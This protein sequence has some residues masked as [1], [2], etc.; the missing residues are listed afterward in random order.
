VG[1]LAYVA[2]V[3]SYRG[4]MQQVRLI[5]A[6]AIP[7]QSWCL[8]VV[9][10]SAGEIQSNFLPTLRPCRPDPCGTSCVQAY[11]LATGHIFGVAKT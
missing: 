4:R 9:C 1:D 10:W 11:E 8:Y 6:H 2:P 3:I 7:T 5:Y